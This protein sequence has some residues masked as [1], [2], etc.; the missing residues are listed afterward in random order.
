MTRGLPS[1][2]PSRLPT[3]LSPGCPRGPC[4]D[5]LEAMGPALCGLRIRLSRQRDFG[6]VPCGQRPGDG[7]RGEGRERREPRHRLRNAEAVQGT[8]TRSKVRR[9]RPRDGDTIRGRGHH[10]R[11]RTRSGGRRYHPRNGETIRET[12]TPSRGPDTIRGTEIPARGLDA[13]RGTEIPAKG[14]RCRLREPEYRPREK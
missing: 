4:M 2:V 11:D 1:R 13:I 9:G 3:R 10:P 14:R 8:G 5:R 12:E 7:P 6:G